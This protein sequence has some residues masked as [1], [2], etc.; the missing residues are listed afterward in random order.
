MD[1]VLAEAMLV[2]SALVVSGLSE[3]DAEGA[4]PTG[5][6]IR[7][8]RIARGAQNLGSTSQSCLA[9]DPCWRAEA[10][11]QPRKPHVRNAAIVVERNA[12]AGSEKQFMKPI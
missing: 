5:G 3:S 7:G 9:S 4:A 6:L 1:F 11:P 2:L 10:F 12:R 8:I